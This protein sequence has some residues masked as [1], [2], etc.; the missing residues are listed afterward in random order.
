MDAG[1]AN[2]HDLDDARTQLSERFISLQDVNFE[3]QRAQIGLLRSTGELE[4]WL[5]GTP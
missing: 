4:K 1:T 3:L 2:L 5:L